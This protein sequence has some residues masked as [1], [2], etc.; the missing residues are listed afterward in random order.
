MFCWIALIVGW[1][2]PTNMTL[3]PRDLRGRRAHSAAITATAPRHPCV[4]VEAPLGVTGC[5]PTAAF[6]VLSHAVPCTPLGPYL[7]CT[8]VRNLAGILRTRKGPKLFFFCR[9]LGQCA[10][11]QMYRSG[12]PMFPWPVHAPANVPKLWRTPRTPRT[13][14]LRALPSLQTPAPC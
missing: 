6:T 13:V 12:R 1:R 14:V 5:K 3:G 10:H 9:S 8:L 7:N 2:S 4:S 11:R